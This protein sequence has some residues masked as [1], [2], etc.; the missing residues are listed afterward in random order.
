MTEYRRNGIEIIQK[1]LDYEL[2]KTKYWIHFLQK[3]DNTF[4]YIEQ[5][6]NVLACNKDRSTLALYSKNSRGKFFLRNKDNVLVGKKRG[7]KKIE[8]D[9]A[10]P[11]GIYK[12]VKKKEQ[13]LD[14]F[15][16]PLA[17]V[18]SYPNVY[19]KY[20]GKTGHGIW[21]HGVP[22]NKE[23]SPYTKGC[24]ALQNNNLKKLDKS[25]KL[26]DTI[27][28]IN[29]KGVKKKVNRKILAWVLTQL[30]RWRYAWIYNDLDLYLSFYD[31]NFVRYDGMKLRQFKRYKK[32][33]FAKKEPKS[34]IFQGITIIPYPNK[35]FFYQIMF[36]EH[37]R[38][39]SYKFDGE[40]ILIVRL[41]K[42]YKMKILTEK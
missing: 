19:D 34:I 25:I 1:K 30:Y 38:S 31:K 16:G 40:K 15:Y 21:I 14:P 36:Y 12:L 22:E 28:I 13:N 10:T 6:S 9:L 37:Y 33:V 11:I 42:K 41:D 17:L 3:Q 18:T 39:P 29:Q 2:T 7:D 5:Y 26:G 35:K 20:L 8:G 32:R 23:R 4:G 27:L 24:I